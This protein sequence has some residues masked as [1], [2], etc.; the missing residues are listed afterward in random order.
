MHRLQAVA[1]VRQRAADDHAHGVVEVGAAQLVLDGD[2]G[3][4][5]ACRPGGGRRS[6]A[7]VG[8][9]IQAFLTPPGA[10]IGT[11]SVAETLASRGLRGKA[12][13]ASRPLAAKL[14]KGSRHMRAN[15][16]LTTALGIAALGLAAC[17][18]TEPTTPPAAS[19]AT[20]Q[21]APAPR[22]PGRRSRHDDRDGRRCADEQRRRGDRHSHP[23]PGAHR[24]ADARPGRGPD[25]RLARHP[26]PRRG[27]LQRRRLRERGRPHQS[28]TRRPTAC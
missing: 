21:T 5:V 18:D 3:D 14:L 20:S 2:R 1:H 12:R 4:I 9:G 8:Q 17:G 28:Q 25:A 26:H 19:T 15:L 10:G 22:G 27:R 7:V 11:S 23:H 24:P 16:L 6:G 13:R